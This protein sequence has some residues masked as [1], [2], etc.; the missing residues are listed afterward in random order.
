MIVNYLAIY[1]VFIAYIPVIYLVVLLEEQELRKRFGAA[2]E[3]YCRE[4]PRFIPRCVDVH[5][6]REIRYSKFINV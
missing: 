4:V 3:K 6:M 5:N 2:Y 1:I